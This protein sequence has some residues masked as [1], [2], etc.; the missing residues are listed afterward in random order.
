M[1]DSESELDELVADLN[2]I[3]ISRRK[4][5]SK[6]KNMDASMIAE[7]ISA[8]VQAAEQSANARAAFREQAF[9]EA[10]SA[11]K[12]EFGSRLE[13]MNCKLQRVTFSAPEVKAFEEPP[14]TGVV[15]NESLDGIKSL[16]EFHGDQANYVSWRQAAHAAFKIF[17]DY[18]G[19]SKHHQATAIIRNKIRGSAD[20]VLSS[21]NTVLNFE[22]IICRLDFTYADKRPLHIVEQEL[23]SLR[24]GNL[25]VLEYYDEVEKKLTLLTN[26]ATMSYDKS[27]APAF[28]EK[29][30]GDALRVFVSGLKRSLSD[31]LFAARPADLPTALALAEEI[32]AN[33]ERYN[34]A[35]TVARAREDKEKKFEHRQ[36]QKQQEGHGPKGKSP[37]YARPSS[38]IQTGQH[39]KQQGESVEPMDVDPSSSKFRQP[40]SFQKGNTS[41]GSSQGQGF[42]RQNG[43]ERTSGVKRQ[44][45]NQLTHLNYDSEYQKIASAAV[46]EVDDEADN[47]VRFLG[48][49]PGCRSLSDTW[50]GQ[51]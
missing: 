22:A 43:S 16:P 11:Q 36:S 47:S 50:P 7:I 15:C 41:Q 3:N 40:T 24:Q 51:H 29:Y 20:A 1:T 38:Q 13:E 31:T 27:V 19:S 39:S 5:N 10:L 26:K 49:T 33:H 30:R 8:A 18:I 17:R 44:G 4:S 14:L 6:Q 28:C 45:I 35:A 12:L 42:R 25:S 37:H 23:G 32:E 21:F 48:E 9:Q 2:L 46:A 34:H